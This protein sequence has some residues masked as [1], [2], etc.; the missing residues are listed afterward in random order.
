MPP[1]A[2]VQ[3]AN[4][5][6]LANN[7]FL[8]NLAVTFNVTSIPLAIFILILVCIACVLFVIFLLWIVKSC[9]R[10]KFIPKKRKKPFK[11][12]Y[13]DEIPGAV[14]E[15]THRFGSLEYSLEYEI[16]REQIKVGVIQANNLA[17]RPGVET[18]DPYVTVTMYKEHGDKLERSGKVQKTGRKHSNQPSWHQLFEFHL[19]EKD[20]KKTTFVFDVYDYDSIGQ[21]SHIGQFRV[22][23]KDLDE[24]EY[25]GKIM[26][27]IGWLSEGGPMIDGIGQIC[28]GLC[29]QPQQGKIIVNILEARQVQLSSSAKKTREPELYVKLTLDYKKTKNL[30][31]FNS[32]PVEEQV[33]PYFNEKTSFS[34]K[35]DKIENCSIKCRLKRNGRMGKRK[36]LGYAILGNT[37]PVTTGV[38]QW[39]EMLRSPNRT[40]VM[41]HVLTP[42]SQEENE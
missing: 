16:D 5:Q 35:P 28:L 21:D 19:P 13:L 30:G 27:S 4:P 15:T 40:H 8:V 11:A 31:S 29:Y 39:E 41:W 38:K 7:T 2:D 23:M 10:R 6:H 14:P 26:E 42:K 33:N 9:I 37:A 25:A 22:Q 24:A 17:V 20:I 34:V 18:L 36:T 32:R 3:Q 12:I 1:A